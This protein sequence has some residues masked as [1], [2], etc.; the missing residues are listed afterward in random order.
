MVLARRIGLIKYTH[1][2]RAVKQEEAVVDYQFSYDEQIRPA[3]KFS[4]GHEA[5]GRWF[6]EELCDNRQAIEELLAVVTR[7]EHKRIGRHQLVGAEFQ[8]RINPDEVEVIALS[9]NLDVDEAL[10]E[11]THLYNEESYAECGLQDFK[12]VLLSWQAFVS[13]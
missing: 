4:L 6:S 12:Q 9:L 3:A 13:P 5:L 8:L 1:Y 7:L 2:D 10:P 11:D